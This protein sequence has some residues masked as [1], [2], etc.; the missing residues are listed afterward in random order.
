MDHGPLIKKKWRPSRGGCHGLSLFLTSWI[1]C[2]QPS[3]FCRLTVTSRRHRINERSTCHPATMERC[4]HH[5]EIG[6]RLNLYGVW[7]LVP[8]DE[9]AKRTVLFHPSSAPITNQL[10][11]KPLPSRIPVFGKMGNLHEWSCYSLTTHC[12][13]G[14][15]RMK[16]CSQLYSFQQM[17]I[18]RLQPKVHFCHLVSPP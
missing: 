14:S 10:T 15:S 18:V 16:K 1:R 3:N 13:I 7:L 5:T 12:T 2:R 11:A 17:Q 9:I 8:W 6:R 4:H